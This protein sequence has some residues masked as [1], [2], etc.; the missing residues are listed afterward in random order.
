MLAYF[1]MFC[2]IFDLNTMDEIHLR[3]LYITDTSR[4]NLSK[5]SLI[6]QNLY[7][8]VFRLLYKAVKACKDFPFIHVDQHQRLGFPFI[9]RIIS[10]DNS[11][12]LNFLERKLMFTK[13]GQKTTPRGI[14]YFS[15]QK[16]H[17]DL[18]FL[19]LA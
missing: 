6:Q 12:F 19:I 18:Q 14:D 13:I 15:R 2:T 11:Q 5:C 10:R 8:Y 7:T 3:C 9:D 4:N 1:T 16:T 17:T